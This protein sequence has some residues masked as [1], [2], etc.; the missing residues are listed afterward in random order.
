MNGTK[1]CQ[2]GQAA[3]EMGYFQMLTEYRQKKCA[4]KKSLPE[5]THSGRLSCH[6]LCALSLILRKPF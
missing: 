3:S 2:A 6:L 4:G 5:P 1:Y